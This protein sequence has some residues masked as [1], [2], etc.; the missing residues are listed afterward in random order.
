GFTSRLSPEDRSSARADQ[1]AFAEE[2]ASQ[3]DLWQ[4]ETVILDELGIALALDMVDEEG[5]RKL[6]DKA[7]SSGETVVTGRAVPMWLTEKADYLSRITAEKHPYATEKLP[8]R[9]GVEW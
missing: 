8:A 9:K 7:L 1:T 6:I 3:I 5:A 2:A 4:P